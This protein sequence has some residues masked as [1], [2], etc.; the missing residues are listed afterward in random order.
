MPG[1]HSQSRAVRLLPLREIFYIPGQFQPS[2]S[3]AARSGKAIERGRR[4]E[5]PTRADWSSRLLLP[6][7]LAWRCLPTT[8]SQAK[9]VPRNAQA[10]GDPL[11][12]IHV[13]QLPSPRHYFTDAARGEIAP[14]R[15]HRR[16]DAG[17]GL[18]EPEDRAE[19]PASARVDH[20]RVRQQTG[21]K[22]RW[23]RQ[24]RHRHAPLRDYGSLRK[25]N[26]Q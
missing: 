21:R 15:D 10:V 18:H 13:H 3:T 19:I 16:V 8:S 24:L 23:K 7:G 22:F 14:P 9:K 26:G 5:G 1:T 17:P 4:A 2:G 12:D 25:M 20:C 6:D 11:D